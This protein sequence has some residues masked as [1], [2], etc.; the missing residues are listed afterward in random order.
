MKQ[1]VFKSGE[2]LCVEVPAPQLQP[3]Q[4][5]VDTHASC[6]SPGTEMSGLAGSGKSLWQ[7]AK[8]NPDK[9]RKAFERMK[10]E[11]VLSVLNQAQ[12]NQESETPC[13][14]S[15][16]GVVVEVGS[17]ANG[18]S[19][20]MRVAIAGAGFANHAEVATV[21][22][23]LAMSIPENVT[24]EEA[25][26][27]AIGG[28]AL[29]GIRR[30]DVSLGDFV[31]VIGC[32]AIGL[33]T[34]QM[35]RAAGCRVI[36][37]DLDAKRLEL[38][39]KLGAEF[40][41]NPAQENVVQKVTQVTNGQGADRVI[42]TV[43]SS[44]SQP[45]R[46]AFEMSR[47]KGRVVLVGVVG[48]ELERG[49]MYKKELDFVISTSYGPGR[50][51]EQYEQKGIDYPYGYV[52]WTEQRNMQAYLQMIADGSVRLSGI[53][54]STYPITQAEDAYQALKSEEKPLLVLLSYPAE[55]QA[56]GG[57]RSETRD[58]TTTNNQQPATSWIPPSDGILKVGLAGVGA[59]VQGM[60]IPNLKALGGQYAVRSVFDLT[61]VAGRQAA[62][63]LPDA[64]VQIETDYD[65][66]LKSDIDMVLI[67]T[68]H[69][70]HAELTMKALKAGKAV[71]VEKPMCITRD[72]FE[73][74][75]EVIEATEAPFM[76]GYN[77][78]FAP[79]V[80]EIHKITD[81]RVNPLVVHY[82]MNAGYVPYDAWVHADEG[83]G[84]IIGEGCHIF[85]LFRSLTRSKA[86]SVSVDGIQPK[87]SAIRASDNMVAT[88]KY[89]DGSICT[90][91]YS[92]LGS[93]DAPKER[94]EVFCDEQ[95]FVLNDYM[96][97]D[98]YGA[99][100]NWEAKPAD[101][102]HLVELEFFA[103]EVM[104]GNRFPI[105]LEEMV[106][107]WLISRQVADQLTA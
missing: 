25:S 49:L 33:L 77:R 13:G 23:N 50:Y 10:T 68:R 46:Q 54:H 53:V 19:K 8:E 42:L 59:F 15:A 79:A 97:L 16:A 43:A 37:I 89:A 39:K 82:T 106:E 78:R 26:T 104:A 55:E 56:A 98:S 94:M 105:P 17:E 87:T 96:K 100:C 99:S 80:Q 60:H 44:S 6:I 65:Q 40:V 102:G 95:L 47:R 36:G 101:K 93:K 27:C 21:P 74:L 84:R 28:I 11:G 4:I 85:D 1:I 72:E 18:Y 57:Q 76:V 92:S 20:G 52:R 34:V 88:V 3:R 48:M 5:L 71:F 91:L 73:K 41:F 86:I 29:Q 31:V 70:S 64:N 32:G 2:V 30:A 66:F 9:L 69:N 45:L 103:A 14:Y 81:K 58:Q 62:R 75:G 35:L 63:Q 107:T 90:L 61:G 38:A 83:G 22:V 24:L 7:K 67:G 51:D 12:A